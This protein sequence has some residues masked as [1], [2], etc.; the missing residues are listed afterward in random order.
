[1]TNNN[2]AFLAD[3]TT[4]LNAKMNVMWVETADEDRATRAI[5]AA[6]NSFRGAT[7]SG[8]HLEFQPLCWS[9]SRGLCRFEQNNLGALTQIRMDAGSPAEDPMAV[10]DPEG[11]VLGKQEPMFI[12]IRDAAHIID[13]VP[14]MR[15]L[16]RD[17]IEAGKDRPLA[18]FKFF[19]F[20]DINPRPRGIGGIHNV[21]L[22]LP[23]KEEIG[24]LIGDAVDQLGSELDDEAREA[25]VGALSGLT[26][27]EAS[28]AIMVCYAS[29]GD[30]DPSLL[31]HHKKQLIKSSALVYREPDARGLA[32]I[33]GLEVLKEHLSSLKGA[34]SEAARA[35][36]LP[37]P[38]GLFLAGLPG[39]GKSLTA[40][41]AAAVLGLP[42]IRMDVG[43][44]FG[45]LV[46]ESERNMRAV[47]KTLDV[48]A[49]CVLFIDEIEK[50]FSGTAAS[51]ERD[52]G[53][54]SRVFGDFLQFLSD[55]QKGVFVM[56]TANNP[57]TLPPELMRA[58]RFDAMYWVG[59]PNKVERAAIAEIMKDA[60]PHCQD[61][62]CAAIAEASRNYTGAEIEQ[63]FQRDMNRAFT[64]GRE[65]TTDGV[66]HCLKNGVVPIIKSFSENLERIRAWG[67]AFCMP[68]SDGEPDATPD[69][70]N[71]TGKRFTQI[72]NKA[73]S[74]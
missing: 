57:H 5:L 55:N 26:Y 51:G 60:L 23:G 9:E 56:A 49:P 29:N 3:I 18:S 53:T 4:A 47:L 52:G 12:V 63:A 1:M 65:V 48:L 61:V 17:E 73:E 8:E 43:A 21:E 7:E 39:C 66:I 64:E 45:S 27:Q 38:K 36:G 32:A 37:Y 40:K 28:D 69:A 59:L 30:L 68:A 2:D 33:G 71:R 62:D 44:V 54:T 20:T 16:L 15:R 10:F 31:M 14:L 72:I 50:G 58:G 35:W 13:N 74:N 22:N 41:C 24:A 25:V 11:P 6:L 46:G 42:L 19:C 67:D 34:F 70:A